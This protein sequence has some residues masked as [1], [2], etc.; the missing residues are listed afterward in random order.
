MRLIYFSFLTVRNTIRVDGHVELVL[1]IPR[2]QKFQV[3]NETRKRNIR[4]FKMILIEDERVF[5]F[6][7]FCNT[8]RIE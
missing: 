6:S 2:L 8:A 3:H 5:F 1:S 4:Y 7:Y